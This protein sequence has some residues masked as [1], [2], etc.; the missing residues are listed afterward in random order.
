[1]N[2]TM[3]KVDSALGWLLERGYGSLVFCICVIAMMYLFQ[4]QVDNEQSRI[5]ADSVTK[6]DNVA[7][8]VQQVSKTLDSTNARLDR[9]DEFGTKTEMRRRGDVPT[10]DHTR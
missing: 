5:L 3:D 4:R 7:S 1:M 6:L 2:E 9:V 8:T 10:L